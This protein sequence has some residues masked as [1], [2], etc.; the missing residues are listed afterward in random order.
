MWKLYKETSI[1]NG[2]GWRNH[3]G[4]EPGTSVNTRVSQVEE[5]NNGKVIQDKVGSAL[6]CQAKSTTNDLSKSNMEFISKKH[7]GEEET[8]ALDSHNFLTLGPQP[9]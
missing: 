9:P 7:D 5:M 8:W 4:L 1:Q 2:T 6:E 3:G